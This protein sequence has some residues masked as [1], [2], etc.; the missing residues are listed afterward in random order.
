MLVE[1]VEPRMVYVGG[2][3]LLPG[4]NQLSSSDIDRLKAGRYWSSLERLAKSGRL[5]FIE[6]DK[7]KIEQIKACYDQDLLEMWLAEAKGKAKKAIEDQLKLI[8]I[9]PEDK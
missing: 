6:A 2:M 4:V 3:K 7:P 1:N 9:E 8:A 5:R